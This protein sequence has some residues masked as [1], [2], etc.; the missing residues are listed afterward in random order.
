MISKTVRR[1]IWTLLAVSWVAAGVAI[2]L[3]MRRTTEAVYLPFAASYM[4]LPALITLVFQ[5]I[6]GEDYFRNLGIS[7]RWNRWFAAASLLPIAITFLALALNLFV[8]GVS[9]SLTYEG[10]FAVVPEEQAR[11]A[12]EKFSSIH[13][14]LFLILQVVQ[15][16][17]AGL[18][19]NA[20]FA[21][22]EELGWR[23]YLL[24]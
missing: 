4:L 23:G 22:G 8:P 6:S 24:R 16:I 11:A 18:T 12:I 21:F 1:Y 3:G 15:S 17:I 19:I 9:F 20:F 10:L 2:A 5:R 13:P 14:A 7:F